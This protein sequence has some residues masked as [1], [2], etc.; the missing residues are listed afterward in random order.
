MSRQL[1]ATLLDWRRR[2]RARCLKKDVEMSEWVFPSRQG[3]ALEE[4]NVRQVFTRMLLKAELRKIRIHNLRHTF[5]TLLLQHGES[6]VY[7]KEQFGHS[8]I[9]ITFDTYG[10]LIP[11]RKSFEVREDVFTGPRQLRELMEESRQVLSIRLQVCEPYDRPSMVLGLNSTKSWS[12]TSMHG[13][14][15]DSRRCLVG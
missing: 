5:A 12:I 9:Q 2:L 1:S 8:S 13:S 6:V 10:H 7:V 14:T 15:P 3:P 11:E 4:R